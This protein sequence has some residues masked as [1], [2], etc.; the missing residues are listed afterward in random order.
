MMLLHFEVITLWIAQSLNKWYR[1][2]C[3]FSRN[4]CLQFRCGNSTSTLLEPK[5]WKSLTSCMFLNIFCH[6]SS[7][8]VIVEYNF[9]LAKQL[10]VWQLLSIQ[11]C[12]VWSMVLEWFLSCK[13]EQKKSENRSNWENHRLSSCR[14]IINQVPLVLAWKL[15]F[16][17]NN[18]M[19]TLN[20]A[21]LFS[22]FS[23][24]SCK[25]NVRK[26]SI[27]HILECWW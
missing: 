19:Q 3:H 4:C 15:L 21:V 23:I 20:Q 9:T 16:S 8:R 7:D 5:L 26:L 12:K 27:R 13:E 11:A 6:V 2:L 10:R 24:W 22:P 17:H 14:Q 18:S 1:W 25:V